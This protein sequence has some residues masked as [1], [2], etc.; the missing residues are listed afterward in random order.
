MG[1][2]L[3]ASGS[4]SV[5]FPWQVGGLCSFCRGSIGP[6]PR[7]PHDL[8]LSL[9]T[10]FFSTCLFASVLDLYKT[11]YFLQRFGCRTISIGFR[12]LFLFAH[13]WALRILVFLT[14][15]P[16]Q[17]CNEDVEIIYL[18]LSGHNV[19]LGEQIHNFSF[20]INRFITR[21]LMGFFF[22]IK[23]CYARGGLRFQRLK[24]EF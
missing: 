20:R 16:I 17:L 15:F 24:N 11:I 2:L 7:L 8:Y 5:F 6:G 4:F 22:F 18:L 12:S 19:T 13:C 23:N 9:L 10:T 14:S 21:N 1:A 3:V